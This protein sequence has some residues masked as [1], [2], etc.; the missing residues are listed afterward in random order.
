MNDTNTTTLNTMATATAASAAATAT[1]YSDAHAGKT[2]AL[3]AKPEET[4][5]VIRGRNPSWVAA[6]NIPRSALPDTTTVPAEYRPLI[7]AVLL[8]ATEGIFRAL[9]GTGE[10]K[11][12]SITLA[13][14][15][16]DNI[17]AAATATNSDSLS[18]EELQALWEQSQTRKDLV[19]TPQY[20]ASPAYRKAVAYFTD[21]VLKLAAR[22]NNLT[23]A[24][25]DKVLARLN[26]DDLDTEFGAFVVRRVE[27]LKARPIKVAE[28]LLDL[29]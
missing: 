22:S 15:N 27:Q 12:A 9:Y 1:V 24:E 7:D 14:F 23:P 5:I 18:R 8:K 17:I 10:L 3:M 16:P 20:Q 25:L 4:T 29:I 2:A 13:P 6:V 11:P 21:M 28:N 26:T 19:T